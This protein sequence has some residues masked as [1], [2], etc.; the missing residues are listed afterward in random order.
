VVVVVVVDEALDTLGTVT[1]VDVLLGEAIDV[2][3][4]LFTSS[5]EQAAR[6]TSTMAPAAAVLIINPTSFG[7]QSSMDS[8]CGAEQPITRST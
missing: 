8:D 5:E 7:T 1:V 4:V 2:G 6:V 3:G